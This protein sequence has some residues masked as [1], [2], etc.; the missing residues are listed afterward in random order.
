MVA[1]RLIH[2]YICFLQKP[3]FFREPSIIDNTRAP[4]TTILRME[5]IGRACLV[6]LVLLGSWGA[7]PQPYLTKMRWRGDVLPE[8]AVGPTLTAYTGA[9]EHRK[10]RATNNDYA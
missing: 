8:A 10:A 2:V 1:E 5:G 7:L 3:R 6:V 9:V 4:K